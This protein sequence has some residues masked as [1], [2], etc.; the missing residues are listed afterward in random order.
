MDTF[1]EW[2]R[3][4]MRQRRLNYRQLARR[5][6]LTTS[7]IRLA[8]EQDVTPSAFVVRRL[9]KFF[10]A[11]P[12]HPLMLAAEQVAAGVTV[13]QTAEARLFVCVLYL[14]SGAQNRFWI[15]ELEALAREEEACTQRAAAC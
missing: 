2:L 15:H 13:A 4:Q 6:G 14:M 8:V 9:A 7:R 3:Q 5:S 12:W 11:D 1:T 10:G